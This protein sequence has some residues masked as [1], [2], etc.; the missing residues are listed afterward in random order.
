MMIVGRKGCFGLVDTGSLG[1]EGNTTVVEKGNRILK[2]HG[3][4]M[5]TQIK[6]WAWLEICH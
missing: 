3:L 1:L 2:F 4:N 5:L 6:I